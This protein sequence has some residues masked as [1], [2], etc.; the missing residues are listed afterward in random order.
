MECRTSGEAVGSLGD[1]EQSRNVSSVI[2][3]FLSPSPSF[4]EYLLSYKMHRMQ[5][6]FFLHPVKAHLSPPMLPL[7]HTLAP[8]LALHRSP[9]GLEA[10]GFSGREIRGTCQPVVLSKHIFYP[11]APCPLTH[12][13]L[14]EELKEKRQISPL[15]TKKNLSFLS[16]GAHQ[17][18]ALLNI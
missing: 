18:H 6:S 17:R 8:H 15:L 7:F 1:W 16:G 4:P 12:L 11:P 5:L 2:Y 14:S 9:R 13:A 10:C 3:L